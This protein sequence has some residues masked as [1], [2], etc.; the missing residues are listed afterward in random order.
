MGLGAAWNGVLRAATAAAAPG[1]AGSCWR[2]VAAAPAAAD[3]DVAVVPP[4][5]LSTA[6]WMMLAVLLPDRRGSG[7]SKEW[8]L[9]IWY[10]CRFLSPPSSSESS[11]PPAPMLF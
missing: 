8:L 9:T 11:C 6:A 2:C 7:V 1:A 4:P 5:A 3:D 10:A